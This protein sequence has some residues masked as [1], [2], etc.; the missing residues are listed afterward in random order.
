[1]D[2]PMVRC[3]FVF[4]RCAFELQI[5]NLGKKDLQATGKLI[6]SK[7]EWRG[8]VPASIQALHQGLLWEGDSYL[9]KSTTHHQAQVSENDADQYT[10]PLSRN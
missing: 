7:Q 4:S 6:T 1:M 10:N 3:T 8:G 9:Q 5:P 2:L